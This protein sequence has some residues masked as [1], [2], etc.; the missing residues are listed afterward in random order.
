ME[1][2]FTKIYTSNSWGSQETPCGPGSTIEAC[3]SIIEKLPIWLDLHSV[4]SII[5]L[6]C[7]DFHWMSHIDLEDIEYDGY[8]IVKEAVEAASKHTASNIAFHH[9]DVLQMQIPKADLILCKDVLIHLPDSDV[10]ALLQAIRSSGSRLLASTTSH[11][12]DNRF[13]GGMKPGEFC[14]I[15]LEAEPFLMKPA[16][17]YVEVTHGTGNPGKFF[18]LFNLHGILPADRRLQS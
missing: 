13:R 8:D 10:L 2:L 3:A 17:Y 18:A 1:D 7:G 5:D 11:G 16:G 12:W 6:G 14:P 4:R 15:D 9:A